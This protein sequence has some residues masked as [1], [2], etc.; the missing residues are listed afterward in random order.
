M[1]ILGW[2]F[3]TVVALFTTCAAASALVFPRAVT[4][5]CGWAGM[6]LIVLAMALMTTVWFTCPFKLVAV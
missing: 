1:A 6:F 4:G 3:L 2:L 5:K